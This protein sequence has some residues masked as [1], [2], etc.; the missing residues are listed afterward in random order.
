VKKSD[1]KKE[2]KIVKEKLRK[3]EV[4]ATT[5]KLNLNHA[6]NFFLVFPQN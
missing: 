3:V 6:N 2:E 5:L 4:L 1:G